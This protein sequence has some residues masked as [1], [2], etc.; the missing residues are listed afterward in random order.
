MVGRFDKEVVVDVAVVGFGVGIVEEV[1]LCR[2][3]CY[4]KGIVVEWLAFDEG[5]RWR[6]VA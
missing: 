2:R 1:G 3:A 4:G 6:T 5:R